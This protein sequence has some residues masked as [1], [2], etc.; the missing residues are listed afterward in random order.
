MESG[1]KKKHDLKG[2]TCI[3]AGDMSPTAFHGEKRRTSSRIPIH[4]YEHARNSKGTSAK[5][6]K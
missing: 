6:K 5:P 3:D 1:V 4:F 2:S